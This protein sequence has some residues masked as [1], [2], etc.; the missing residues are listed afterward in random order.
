MLSKT[1]GAKVGLVFGRESTGLTRSELE[2]CDYRFT[3]STCEKYPTLNLANSVAI[4]LYEISRLKLSKFPSSAGVKLEQKRILVNLLSELASYVFN[5]ER[6]IRDARI[7]AARLGDPRFL[8][9]HEA[10]ILLT[11]ISRLKGLVERCRR[12]ETIVDG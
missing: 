7:A 9:D 3:I 12:N 11:L 1:T 10:A 6:R 4:T 2:L 5:D 8:S